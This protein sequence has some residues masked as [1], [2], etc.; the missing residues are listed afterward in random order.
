VWKRISRAKALLRASWPDPD[1][2]Q[3]TWEEMVTGVLSD[4]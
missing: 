4:Q 1:E 3:L 2:A